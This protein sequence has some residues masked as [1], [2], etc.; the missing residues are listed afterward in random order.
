MAPE[1]GLL[2]LSM[3]CLKPAGWHGGAEAEYAGCMQSSGLD[4]DVLP[5]S[6]HHTG[7]I[8]GSFEALHDY[9]GRPRSVTAAGGLVA[10]DHGRC[11]DI[12]EAGL[13]N[14]VAAGWASGILEAALPQAK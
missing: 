6:R 12:G 11:S 4:H 10:A 7:S 13:G 2:L 1:G 8:E 9:R 3:S 14:A 5:P